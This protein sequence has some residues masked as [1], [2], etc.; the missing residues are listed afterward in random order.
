MET[1]NITYIS[2]S[3]RGLIFLEPVM[4]KEV[5]DIMTLAEHI[6]GNRGKGKQKL[7][8]LTSL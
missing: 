3:E 8:Y 7:T 2:K 1:K 6:D 5:L 4:K